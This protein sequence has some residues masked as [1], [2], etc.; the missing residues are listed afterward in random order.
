SDL[1]AWVLADKLPVRMQVQL[2]K[3][4]WGEKP[5]V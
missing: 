1:A 3:I 4:L 2:H 5:G